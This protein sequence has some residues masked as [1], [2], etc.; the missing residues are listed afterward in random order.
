VEATQQGRKP[1]GLLLGL[2]LEANAFGV[3]LDETWGSIPERFEIKAQLQEWEIWDDN[4]TEQQAQE[5]FVRF[6]GLDLGVA[7]KKVWGQLRRDLL[8]FE[9]NIACY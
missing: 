4:L 6:S 3:S 2:R 8:E 1:L 5:Q 7:P 9:Q